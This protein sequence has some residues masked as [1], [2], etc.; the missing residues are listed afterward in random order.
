[1]QLSDYIGQEVVFL[2][3]DIDPEALQK[4][5]IHGVETGGVWLESQTL[6]NML[7]QQFKAPSSQRTLIWFYPYDK[8]R[9]GFVGLEKPG[10]NE[11]A[12]GI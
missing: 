5:I 1:M 12:F 4:V 3:P 2:I 10:L 7:L 9:F 8:I 6:T 11:K